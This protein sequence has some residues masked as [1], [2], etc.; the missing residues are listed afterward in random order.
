MKP[1]TWYLFINTWCRLLSFVDYFSP[2]EK[3]DESN[4]EDTKRS[5]VGYGI[6]KG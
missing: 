2:K 4:S 3:S 6:W 1:W 5:K